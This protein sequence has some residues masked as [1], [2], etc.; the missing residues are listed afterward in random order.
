M[1]LSLQW[2]LAQGQANDDCA[3][4]TNLSPNAACTAGT[5]GGS[6]TQAGENTSGSCISNTFNR[7]VWYTFTANNATMYLDVEFT[8]LVS[9]MV[10]CPVRL[11]AL[12]YG[13]GVSC[14]P[15]SG[16]IVGCENMGD[17]DGL[18]SINLTSL[19]VGAVYRVQVGYASGGGCSIPEFC[20]RTGNHEPSYSCSTTGGSA[21]SFAT[22]PSIPTVTS[23]CPADSTPELEENIADTRCYSFTATNDTVAFN[24]I[25]NS[26][27]GAGNVTAFSWQLFNLSCAGGVIQ[28]GTLASLDFTGLTIGNSYTFCYSFT[29]PAGCHHNIHWPYTVGA[30]V[31]LGHTVIMFTGT[32]D[33]PYANQLNWI[34]E[35]E[36]D[37]AFIVQRSTNGTTFEDLGTVY[38]VSGK[39]EFIRHNDNFPL[40]AMGNLKE[41]LPYQ[42]YEF[43][44]AGLLPGQKDYYYRLRFE[45]SDGNEKY[46]EVL[47]LLR[48]AAQD[49]AIKSIV[50]G[51]GEQWELKVFSPA[52]ATGI[53][54]ITDMNGKCIALEQVQIA[55][56]E[57]SIS[58]EIQGISSGL[59]VARM[60]MDSGISAL[61]FV[62]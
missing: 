26:N 24:V 38:P 55:G 33:L 58:L 54:D 40:P 56:G 43:E 44:D 49:F 35:T 53:L 51:S 25:I 59:Y 46:S 3:S 28:S 18:I 41:E 21:C 16:D 1:L 61:R 45:D 48:N 42:Q 39:K 2:G 36:G 37:P 52:D 23:T 30:S 14:Q 11:T 29:V 8:Q 10:W 47:H 20:I 12:V 13:P 31:L 19:T 9:G 27:C 32:A 17:N 57:T 6:G 60:R 22:N 62:K 4:A 15:G 5:L 7:S 50:P 34:A